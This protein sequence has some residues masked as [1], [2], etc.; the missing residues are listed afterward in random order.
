MAEILYVKYNRTRAERFQIRTEI[1]RKKGK[2]Y[3]R[4]T[5]LCPE[6]RGHIQSFRDKYEAL[7]RECEALHLS[8]GIPWKIGSSRL[9]A[10]RRTRRRH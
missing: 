6:G 4:K 9:S 10:R 8:R 3:T 2:K 7:C 5:A 1:V